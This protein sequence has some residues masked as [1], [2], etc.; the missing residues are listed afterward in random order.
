MD[1]KNWHEDER[2]RALL[3]YAYTLGKEDGYVD[4]VT[5]GWWKERGDDEVWG[6]VD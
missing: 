2:V 1:F 3:E 6:D 5:N 4:G